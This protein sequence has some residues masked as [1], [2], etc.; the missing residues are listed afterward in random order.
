MKNVHVKAVRVKPG[1]AT[2]WSSLPEVRETMED[3]RELFEDTTR[4]KSFN[5][6]LDFPDVP[7]VVSAL[8]AKETSDIMIT[9]RGFPK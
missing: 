6:S 9:T 7:V 5:K 8:T 4:A 3:L 2:M 1:T